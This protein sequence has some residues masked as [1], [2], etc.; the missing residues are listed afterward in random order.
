MTVAGTPKSMNTES[1]NAS[2]N[3]SAL[4]ATAI[5]A[6]HARYRD[7]TL[8]PEALVESIAMRT[9]D[10]PHH[11]WIRA[12]T[13]DEMLV[14]VRALAGKSPD[15]LPLYGVPF[16][17]KDNID[18]AGIPTTAACPAFAYTPQRSAA[19]V[20]R[21]IAA[22]AIPIGKANLD[23]FATGLNGTRS[24]Y[25]AC[26]NA[27]DPRY[28]SGGS[29]SGSA[30]AVALGVASFSLGTDTAGSGRVPA[31][32]HG[33]LGVKPTLSTVSTRG[34]VPACKSLDCVSIFATSASDASTV[35]NVAQGVDRDDAYARAVEAG[36]AS[37]PIGALRF[38]VPKKSQLAFF[39]NDAFA[40]LFDDAVAAL[41]ARGASVVEI[42]FDPFLS[43]AR[44]LY[45][46][47]FVAE[48]HAGIRDFFDSHEDDVHPVVRGI[49][50]G[51]R[52]YSAT[53]AFAAFDSLKVLRARTL[54]TWQ[55]IDAIVMPTAGTIYTIDQMLTKPVEYN[56]NL[57]YYTNF[58]NLLDLAA[59]AIPTG[60]ARGGPTPGMPFGV[61]FVGPAFSDPLLLSI[62]SEFL[63]EE[64]ARGGVSAAGT[65]ST[66]ATVAGTLAAGK[67]S[68][69]E[70]G[71]ALGSST[72]VAAAAAAVPSAAT[73]RVAVVGAHLT[74]Q[75]LNSQLTERQATCVAV[76]TTSA[77]YRLYALDTRPV[78]KPGLIRVG[79][80]GAPIALEVWEMPVV[81]FGSF[82]DLI[83]APLGIGSVELADGS[84]VKGFVC[85]SYVLSDARDITE[86]G[87]WLAYLE[88]QRAAQRSAQD[89]TQASTTIETEGGH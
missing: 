5:G 63:G 78:A 65:A 81:H 38:G 75:P 40:A 46:G 89:S 9:A 67:P 23:Q 61:T 54:T 80:G 53:D 49:I 22:G 29:S 64:I 30:V 84:T 66:A 17:I 7:G 31:M 41:V 56:S 51:A 71:A 58:V 74:G 26:R 62:A 36:P 76:T 52:G 11:A 32:F 69:A 42:D 6:L 68:G 57:G 14:Y 25:G 72:V 2:T 85:E 77:N 83:G 19:V 73:I 16:A 28:V 50:A 43:V 55:S 86:H 13:R 15:D 1:T 8:T 21:L 3:D 82:V 10:D 37:K 4:A 44:L 18:L 33:L 45:G 12:L 70:P 47:A 20:E 79:S 24:P 87:G 59:L 48:R 39:G 34:V 88:A 27:I 60:V 35:L